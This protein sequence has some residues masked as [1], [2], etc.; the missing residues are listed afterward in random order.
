MARVALT[1]F[2]AHVD[3]TLQERRIVRSII[4][5]MPANE[6]F[7][8]LIPTS[9]ELLILQETKRNDEHTGKDFRR[10]WAMLGK[11]D[12]LTALYTEVPGKPE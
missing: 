11:I 5:Q 6:L 8:R 12:V 1:E 10:K 4:V 3:N 2:P 9:V 7:P